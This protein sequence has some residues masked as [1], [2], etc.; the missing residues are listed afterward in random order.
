MGKDVIKVLTGVRRCGKSTILALIE[1]E[2]RSKG[3]P[4]DRIVSMNFESA[5]WAAAAE[6]GDALYR[7]VSTRLEESSGQSYLLLDE[8]QEVPGWEK[9]VNA[10]R[11][12]YDC[13]IYITGSNAHLLS[14]E[15]ATLLTGRYVSI[16]VQPLSYAELVSA[17]P[18]RG[19]DELFSLYRTVGGMP[20]IASVDFAHADAMVYLGDVLSSILLK[21]VVRRK[22]IRNVDQLDRVIRYFISETGT[23]FSAKNI[24]NV[25][26]EQ[27][28]SLS[29]ETLYEY[30]DGAVEAMLL[31]RVRRFDVK[32][33]DVL[34]GEEKVYVIDQ[35]FR[36]ALFGNNGMRIDLVLE[37]IVF[38]DLR[39]RGFEVYVG[40]NGTKEIDF[41]A[42]RQGD[43]VYVQVAYLL[44]QE[45]TISR[46]FGAY[47]GVGDN[48]P[49]YVVTMDEVDFSR[50]GIRH[51]NIKDFLLLDTLV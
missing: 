23:S 45:E 36:E 13:D 16:R 49:K 26:K 11:A 30:L 46:E 39:R 7:M 10:L 3:V 42:E 20:F 35:G 12:D 21:D 44:A 31:A 50:D 19:K 24:V 32:G 47:A 25:M 8:V 29:R 43:R 18:S 41:V 33:R 34:R 2:L 1:D 37:T 48:Y 15:L 9:A 27:G 5:R 40:K 28:F 17:Y 38:N 22:G 6:S 4:A 14:S 51:M